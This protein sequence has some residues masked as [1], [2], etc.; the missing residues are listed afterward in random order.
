MSQ[1][2]IAVSVPQGLDPVYAN[3][4]QV[5]YKEDEFTF[6]FLHE[7]PGTNQARAKSIVSITPRHA[8]NLIAVLSRSMKDYEEK[9][10]TIQAPSEKSGETNVTMRGYS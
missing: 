5:A 6:I 10:G 8:K 9:F 4:I 7:I 2:E 1:K 3:R